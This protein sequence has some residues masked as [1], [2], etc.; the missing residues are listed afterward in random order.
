LLLAAFVA[1]IVATGAVAADQPNT[2]G[3]SLYKRLGGY[4]TIT[5][6][7]QEFDRRWVKEPMLNALTIGMSTDSGNRAVQL[8][9]EFFCEQAGGPCIYIG[10]DMKTVHTGLNLTEEHWTA[11]MRILSD[12]MDTVKVPVKEKSEALDLFAS[13][14]ADVGIR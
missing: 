1:S 13:F 3:E 6:V 10:R 14:K 8:F 2:A 5:A 9:I 4:D 7:V 12:S 11:F